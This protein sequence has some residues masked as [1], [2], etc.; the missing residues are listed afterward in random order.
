MN[1]GEQVYYLDAKS[2]EIKEGK[3][4]GQNIS[5]NGYAL[6]SIF[7]GK[8]QAK[9][10]MA[11]VHSTKESCEEHKKTVVPIM[12]EAEEIIKIA[13]EKVDILRLKVIGDPEHKEIAEAI[14]N[15]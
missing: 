2:K 11:H 14:T 9:T 13:T 15:G 10:E 1:I 12:E 5:T 3:V 8:D 6:C 7:D 4:V